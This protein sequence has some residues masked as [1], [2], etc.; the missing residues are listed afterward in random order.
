[1]VDAR[2]VPAELIIQELSSKLASNKDLKVPDWVNYLKAG[3]HREN[4][5]ENGEQWYY[6]RSASLLRKLYI[7]GTL[8]ISRLSQEYG[9]R[10]DRGSKRYHPSS[11][12]R[13]IVRYIL[14]SLESAGLVKKVN[15]GRTLSPAGQSLME[16]AASES[17]KK[18]A[19]TYPELK[20][21]L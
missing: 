17:L 18:Y 21:Y 10:V 20:K 16:K 19:E 3:I 6:C 13:F 7:K 15:G 8:G 11:G 2:K 5:W 1:M 4:S 14:H 12:S 9:G